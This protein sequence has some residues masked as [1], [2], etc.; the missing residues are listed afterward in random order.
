MQLRQIDKAR[1]DKH[2]KITFAAIIAFMLVVSLGVSNL[3][4]QL[5]GNPGG[6]NFWL[7]VTGVILA[8]LAVAALIRRYR[9]H[10]F[11]TEVMYVWD[12]KQGLNRIHRKQRK[13][14][15]AVAQGDRNATII[16]NYHYQASRQLYELDNNTITLDDLAKA[17]REFQAQMAEHGVSV[18]LEEF[19]PKL[20]ERY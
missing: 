10:P 14:K 6:N 8:A 3:L 1:Y 18:T 7:N 19:D 16:M 13:I 15:A 12:L 9:A 11:L 20:L 17:E 2:F 5:I 4:I